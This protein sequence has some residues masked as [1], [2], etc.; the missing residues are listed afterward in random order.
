M[1]VLIFGFGLIGRALAQACHERGETVRA[2][3]RQWCSD[4]ICLP[5]ELEIFDLNDFSNF[6]GSLKT[7]WANAQT[8][9]LCL[10]PSG[11][12]ERYA[13]SVGNLIAQAEKAGV[14][15]F[16]YTSST[17]VF[18][19]S[20]GEINEH[21]PTQAQTDNAKQMV[22]IEQTLLQ[23]AIPHRDVLRLG[24]LYASE[25]HPLQNLL[26]KN[27][28]ISG[29]HQWVNMVHRDRVVAGI[30]RAMQTPNGARV[31]HFVETPHLRKRDFYQREA[32]RLGLP[33][34]IW[35]V[36]E[37]GGCEGKRV[38]TAFDDLGF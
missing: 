6:S 29:A 14:S 30:L 17:S 32:Q 4:D 28:A 18:G 7:E 34:P 10:P 22:Q 19:D 33:V 12:G 13:A 26:R 36:E 37:V 9:V 23:A 15:H 21:S 35:A 27:Q 8:W 25:R 38:W 3:R 31:R 1:T 24:G 11:L 2:I 20:V 16:I 5:I